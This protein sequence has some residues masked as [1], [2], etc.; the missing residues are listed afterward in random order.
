[1]L[2]ECVAAPREKYF[3]EGTREFRNPDLLTRRVLAYFGIEPKAFDRLKELDQE[4][5]HYR[6]IQ[7][8]LRSSRQ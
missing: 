3:R 2:K 6:N 7:V 4:I 1:M 5:S 8:T